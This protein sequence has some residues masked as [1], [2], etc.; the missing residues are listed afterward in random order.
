MNP[1][2]AVKHLLQRSS[3]VLL[4]L[5]HNLQNVLPLWYIFYAASGLCSCT[6]T[7]VRWTND[8]LLSV[9]SRAVLALHRLHS[10]VQLGHGFDFW[11][12]SNILFA[13][14]V[15]YLPDWHWIQQ[16]TSS[17]YVHNVQFSKGIYKSSATFLD[18]LNLSQ[19]QSQHYYPR[20]HASRNWLLHTP[21]AKRLSSCERMHLQWF[22]LTRGSIL[23]LGLQRVLAVGGITRNTSL[24]QLETH[25]PIPIQVIRLLTWPS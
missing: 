3:S 15:L 17:L 21:T 19:S 16:I 4:P 10:S 24:T 7:Q 5:L 25:H 11:W 13:T 6:G 12:I 2:T 8:D 20:T 14:K 1:S 18:S 9:L 23:A 22:F